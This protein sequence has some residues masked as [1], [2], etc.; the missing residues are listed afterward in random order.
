MNE[1]PSAID[2]QFLKGLRVSCLIF[3]PYAVEITFD[4]GS[5]LVSEHLIEYSPVAGEVQVLD[6]QKGFDHVSIHRI[7]DRRI[8]DIRREPFDLSL[9]FEDGQ[10]LKV[11]SKPGPLESGHLSHGGV[12]IVF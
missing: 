3:Q 8:A 7:V 11:I 6:I 4:D 9:H 12:T 5:S 10:T 2:V 1:F